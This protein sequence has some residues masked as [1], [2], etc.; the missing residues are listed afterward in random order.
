MIANTQ[1]YKENFDLPLDEKVDLALLSETFRP[2]KSN[3]ENTIESQVARLNIQSSHVAI[4]E[5]DDGAY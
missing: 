2:V 1:T 4:R 3:F 5:M